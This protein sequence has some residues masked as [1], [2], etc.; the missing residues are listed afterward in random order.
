MQDK[1]DALAQEINTLAAKGPKLER[2]ERQRL[3]MARREYS[4]LYAQTPEAAA[5][6]IAQEAQARK[7]QAEFASI[8][9][10]ADP[11][12]RQLTKLLKSL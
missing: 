5:Q 7:L 9:D 2:W 8:A 6:R 1:L 4:Q 10:P 11:F 12:D 3:L